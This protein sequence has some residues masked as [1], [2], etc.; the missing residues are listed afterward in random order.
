MIYSKAFETNFETREIVIL[1]F[2]V[3]TVIFPNYMYM[4]IGI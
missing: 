3:K 4:D 2:G 1:Y